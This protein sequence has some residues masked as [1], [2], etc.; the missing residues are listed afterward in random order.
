MVDIT[1]SSEDE[2][3]PPPPPLLLQEEFEAALPAHAA[4]QNENVALPVAE[5]Q[6]NEVI[7][8]TQDLVNENEAL[9]VG[10]DGANAKSFE[11]LQ[12]GLVET[13]T[14]P[15]DPSFL[16]QASA[17]SGPS[18]MAIRCWAKYFASVDRSLPTVTIPTS[19]VDFLT[20]LMLKQGSYDW[21]KDF[22]SSPAWN[23]FR[24]HFDGNSFPFTLPS[25]KPSV[26]ITEISCTPSI[27]ITEN[28]IVV[29]VDG[30]SPP[31]LDLSKG[32]QI[33]QP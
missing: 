8:L 24:K 31:S 20:L 19:W 28:T 12:V 14:P 6:Q 18:P 3:P 27:S 15:V 11:H 33:I 16:Q 9:S 10:Q 5:V 17:A 29:S 1:D 13:F 2:S 32:K 21:A 23:F 22:L 25:S 26:T 30:S 4:Q 7:A